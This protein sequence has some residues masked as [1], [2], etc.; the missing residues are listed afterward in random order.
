MVTEGKQKEDTIRDLSH[1]LNEILRDF[2]GRLDNRFNRTPAVE[3]TNEA[4][5]PLCPNILDEI[6]EE[7]MTARK[8]LS[9][10]SAFISSDVLPKIN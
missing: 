1:E 9:S 4:E 5:A 6:I 7:L 10:I 8:H 2:Q 3:T